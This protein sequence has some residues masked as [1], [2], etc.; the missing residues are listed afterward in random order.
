MLHDVV[1]RSQRIV[2]VVASAAS[3]A[4]CSGR[5]SAPG[6]PSSPAPGTPQ[7]TSG[8]ATISGTIVGVTS[9]SQIKTRQ[10]GISVTVTGSSSAATVDGAGHFT[11]TNVPA[12]RIDL[13]FMGPGIDAHLPLD[14]A[15]RATVVIVVRVSG[16]DAHLEDD[17]GNP[18]S[19]AD[20]QNHAEVNGSITAG[21]LSGSCAAHNLTFMVGAIRVVTN[22]STIFRDGPCEALKA[23]TRVEAKGARQS[24]GSLLAASIEGEN[25][26][27]NQGEVEL[28]GSIAAGSLGGSCASNS[29]S[30]RINS[31]QVK[32]DASTQFKDTS[33]AS[34]KAGDSVEVK[35]SRQADGS[36]LAKRVE[37]EK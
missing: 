4:S 24:D 22:A 18:G 27:E 7:P 34:L 12:G 9:A 37:R 33:C 23:G 25:D 35:G 8:S 10:A 15:E 3:I 5:Q 16:N 20:D 13:H 30:F 29:L 28:K 11:L 21:S 2:I 36:V 31:T 26:D 14:V 19:G 32:T 6:A 17:H 1:R